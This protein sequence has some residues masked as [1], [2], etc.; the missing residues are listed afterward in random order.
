MVMKRPSH[1]ELNNKILLA[2]E[3]VSEESVSIL[4]PIVIAIDALN[5]G[6]LVEEINKVLLEILNELRPN[7]YAGSHPPQRS[8]EAKIE[9]SELFAFRWISGRFGC[10]IYFKFAL[11]QLH[12]WVVSLH[13]DRKK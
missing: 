6:Y 1:K 5:L 3:A 9:G 2:K 8:Y 10:R 11:K 7:Y 12:L 4:N 13:E